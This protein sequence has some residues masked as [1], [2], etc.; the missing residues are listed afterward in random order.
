MSRLFLTPR[1]VDF[2]NDRVKEFNRDLL[3]HKIYLYSIDSLRTNVHEVYRE[4]PEKIYNNPIE[5]PCMVKFIPEEVRTNQFGS[6]EY[7][8][9]EVYIQKRDIL[10]NEI[11]VQEGDFFSFG[12]QFFEAVSVKTNNLIYM[13]I[14][15]DLGVK[16]VGRQ[17]R[18]NQFEA[19]LFGPLDE[20]IADKDAIQDTFIQ[21]RGNKENSLG[22]TGDRRELRENGTLEAPI[23]GPAEI[24]PRGES[25]KVK[26]GFYD[27]S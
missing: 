10:D 11:D 4:A 12:L 14:E 3:G 8:T 15:H 17:A 16:I 2:I 21:H 26:S 19:K 24:S 9:I 1:V 27:E 18:K 5:L 7:S 25:G 20:S 6:E 13:Q 22:P 23:Q